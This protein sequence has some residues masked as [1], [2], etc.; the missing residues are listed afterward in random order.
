MNLSNFSK[1][2]SLDSLIGK[3]ELFK[4]PR[5]IYFTI[6]EY[7]Q[8]KNDILSSVQKKLSSKYIVVRSS[9]SDEDGEEKSLAGQ[10]DSV[11]NIKLNDAMQIEKAINKVIES[12]K[13]KRPLTNTDEIIIQEMIYEISMSGV[14]FTHDLNTGAPYYVINYDDISGKTDTVTSGEGEYSNRTLYIYRQADDS[15][16]SERFKV[17][18][19]AIKELENLLRNTYLDIEFALG[20]DLRPYLFQVRQI[21]TIKDKDSLNNKKIKSFLQSVSKKLEKTLSADSGIY[22]RNTTL[23]Q[24]PDWNPAEMIGR[25]PRQLASSLY[26][27]LITDEVWAN[28][29][30]IMHYYCPSKRSLMILLAGQPFIDT[31][32]SFNSFLPEKLPKSIS[33]KLVDHWVETLRNRPELHDKVEFEV[34]ITS[35]TFDLDRKMSQLIGSVLDDKEKKVFKRAL[36]RL[37]KKLLSKK[38]KYSISYSLDKIEKLKNLNN[39]RKLKDK[40]NVLKNIEKMIDDCINFGTT[41]FSILARHGFIAKTFLNSLKSLKIL[42]ENQINIIEGSVDTVAGKL[43]DDIIKLKSKLI[44]IKEFNKSYG[45]LR[46]GT[47]DILSKRYDQMSGFMHNNNENIVKRKKKDFKPSKNQKNAINKLLIDHDLGNLNYD[48]FLKYIK[49]SIEGREYAKFVFTKTVSDLLEEIAFFSE[50]LGLSRDQI[51]YISIN[52]ILKTSKNCN[53]NKLFKKLNELSKINQV[54]H[55]ISSSIRLPQLLSDQ[56]NIFVIPFQVSQPNFITQKKI[57]SEK[58]LLSNKSDDENISGKII[59]IEGADPGYDWIFSHKIDGLITKYGG[60]NSHMAVRCAEFSIPA[61]IGCGEQ[62]FE[63]SIK[64]QKILLD[65]SAGLIKKVY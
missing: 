35:Y 45:H 3:L 65:C 17:L 12:Y 24:M 44:N 13:K 47:Y 6:A 31:R 63:E 29:R 14:V 56:E 5:F 64:Y 11:L 49:D 37:T 50:E 52:D 23:G 42:N 46:P 27:K 53:S 15:L 25:V 1:A 38:G 18:I 60:A 20:N 54:N 51:S 55:K 32:L 26:I 30:K 58:L 19:K 9:A 10:Y 62:R 8:N 21:T 39:T 57:I 7:R 28:A 41:Y 61:A 36:H 48:S 16:H 40:K 2:K 59:M 22:G 33:E 43:V 4:I 34:A